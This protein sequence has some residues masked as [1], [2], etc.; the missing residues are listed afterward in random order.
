MKIRSEIRHMDKM[1]NK[2]GQNTAG[3]PIALP[4]LVFL[5]ASFLVLMLAP[6]ASADVKGAYYMYN[7]SNM[8][9]AIPYSW[10]GLSVDKNRNEVYV[11]YKNDIEIFNDN[12]MK[13]YSFGDDEQLT[14]V[15]YDIAVDRDGSIFLLQVEGD[16]YSVMRCNY[17]GEPVSQIKFKNFPPEFS[18]IFPNRIIYRDGNLYLADL[19]GTKKVAVTDT[20]GIFRDGYDINALF[21]LDEIDGKPGRDKEIAGFSVDQDGNMLFT[22]PTIFRAFTLSPDG[23]VRSFG[24]AGNIPGKFSVVAGIASDDMGNLYVV[25]TLKSVVMVF[26]N[27][28]NFISE[29]GYRGDQPGNLIAPRSIVVNNTNIYVSQSRK[30][31]VSVYRIVQN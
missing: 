8:T 25:D 9:G 12:G 28:F 20:N 4:G 30:R 6:H 3:K 7:L 31:G 16:A 23:K 14:G 21:G 1:Q 29:F 18:K 15:I 11:I 27:N 26:D 17:R 10:A 22:V 19:M 2:T 5:C 13:I 24:E